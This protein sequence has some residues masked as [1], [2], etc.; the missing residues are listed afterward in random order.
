MKLLM[1]TEPKY[2]ICH[3][4]KDVNRFLQVVTALGWPNDATG[5]NP[6]MLNSMLDDIL[7][8]N[9]RLAVGVVINW[10]TIHS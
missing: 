6:S 2:C 9:L 8:E 7:G 5:Y 10:K 3:L 4:H 1:Q